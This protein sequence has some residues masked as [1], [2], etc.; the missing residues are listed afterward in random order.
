MMFKTYKK[1]SQLWCQ[2]LRPVKFIKFYY[3]KAGN[4]TGKAICI[5]LVRFEIQLKWLIT[6]ILDKV[7]DLLNSIHIETVQYDPVVR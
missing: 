1:R 6:I 3:K 4:L 7:H 2:Q 5:L